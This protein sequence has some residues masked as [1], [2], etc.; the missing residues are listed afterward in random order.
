MQK[1]LARDVQIASGT[2]LQS[3][4]NLTLFAADRVEACMGNLI[5]YLLQDLRFTFRQLGRAPGFFATAA[6]TLALGIGV[7]TAIF[8]LVDALLL[9]PLPVASPQQITSWRC[10]QNHGPQLPLFS[11][12][13]YRADTRP[14][15]RALSAV[16]L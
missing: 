1:A 4:W 2:A 12:P 3:V 6:L 16:S 8:S 9:R 10:A 11:W 7:N 15:H 5:Q 14:E 13:E